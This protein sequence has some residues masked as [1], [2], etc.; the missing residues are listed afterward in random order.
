MD[1]PLISFTITLAGLAY[2]PA[3]SYIPV[4]TTY[5]YIPVSYI[6]RIVS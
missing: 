6:E 1:F 5:R 4:F 2:I 3:V